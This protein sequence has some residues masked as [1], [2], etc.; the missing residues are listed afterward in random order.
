MNAEE[1]SVE[2]LV[3]GE[4]GVGT[5]S[6]CRASVIE[7]WR[8]GRDQSEKKRV[9]ECEGIISRNWRATCV[10]VRGTCGVAENCEKDGSSARRSSQTLSLVGTPSMVF[11]WLAEIP[12]VTARRGGLSQSNIMSL[13][14]VSGCVEAICISK[15]WLSMSI[16][17]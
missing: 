9:R 4:A 8:R 5:P 1:L 12:F 11:G 10:L 15:C 17:S 14:G 6:L 2:G 13:V 16:A 7:A 3:S